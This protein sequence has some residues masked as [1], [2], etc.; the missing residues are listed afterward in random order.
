LR[1]SLIAKFAKEQYRYVRDE[2]L[3][4][5]ACE[6]KREA[7]AVR[8]AKEEDWLKQDD[9]GS[10]MLRR[11]YGKLVPSVCSIGSGQFSSREHC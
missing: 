8:L 1:D 9:P 6:L 11:I 7:T 5:L 2:S 3:R 4:Y 10:I